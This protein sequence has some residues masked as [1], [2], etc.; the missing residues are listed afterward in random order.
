MR[1]RGPFPP[2][3]PDH[4]RHD[5]DMWLGQFNVWSPQLSVDDGPSVAEIRRAHLERASVTL[6]LSF[7]TADMEDAD[8]NNP[9][10]PNEVWIEKITGDDEEINFLAEGDDIPFVGRSRIWVWGYLD[11]SPG[12]SADILVRD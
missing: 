1:E 9:L 3:L 11:N 4:F 12:A 6:L 7:R 8:P 2:G 5:G 10:G